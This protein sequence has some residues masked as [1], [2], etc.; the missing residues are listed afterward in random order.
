MR[1]RH[2]PAFIAFDMGGLWALFPKITPSYIDPRSALA[3]LS[4]VLIVG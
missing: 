4:I 3:P 1:S 2:L